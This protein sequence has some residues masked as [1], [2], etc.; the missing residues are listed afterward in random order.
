MLRFLTTF[1]TS[2]FVL[3]LLTE[4]SAKETFA[5][6]FFIVP[7][8]YGT[9]TLLPVKSPRQ[10]CPRKIAHRHSGNNNKRRQLQQAAIKRPSQLCALAHM[11]G[12]EGKTQQ[13]DVGETAKEQK[14]AS[15]EG[16]RYG[17]G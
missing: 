1:T 4:T 12:A 17:Q 13:K 5:I 2:S 9:R 3:V 6:R 11:V 16:R 14:H 10:N 7:A 8:K 15:D